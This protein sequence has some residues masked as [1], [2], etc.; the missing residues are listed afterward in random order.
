MSNITMV[1]FQLCLYGSPS[2]LG[3][4]SWFL[5]FFA[6]IKEAIVATTSWTHQPCVDC[7]LI[8]LRICNDLMRWCFLQ[9][10]IVNSLWA[11]LPAQVNGSIQIIW[12]L[13]AVI[14]L[15]LRTDSGTFKLHTAKDM[16]VLLHFTVNK[17]DLMSS[18]AWK[19]P[20]LWLFYLLEHS[21]TCV[22]CSPSSLL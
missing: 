19:Q 3:H 17:F 12:Q 4:L 1:C 9:G 10:Q 21:S 6:G 5:P 20:N 16:Q 11:A 18:V 8:V 13:C 14:S 22:C 2:Y 7:N 15:L